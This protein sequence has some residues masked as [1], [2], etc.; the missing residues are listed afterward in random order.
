MASLDS[1]TPS[2]FIYRGQRNSTW[3]LRSTLHRT[4][5]FSGFSN[6][7][8][9]F[10][11]VLPKV[12]EAIETWTGRRWDLA[13]PHG[14]AKFAAFLQHNGFPTPLLDWTRSPYIAAYFAFESVWN[15]EPQSD[16]VSIYRFSASE[17]HR[18]YHQHNN[19][20]DLSP[21]VS[22]LAPRAV[23][24]HKLALQQGCFTWSTIPNAEEHIE[25]NEEF[26]HQFLKKYEIPAAERPCVMREL[27]SMGITAIH[28]MPSVESV[29][30][31]AWEDFLISFEPFMSEANSQKPSGNSI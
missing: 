6:L 8:I 28:M 31:K 14:L 16:L 19:V 10:D 26:P 23:G 15:L 2:A 24:N 7:R 13:H 12:H 4:G 18:R 3:T 30:R 29:C 25:A 11:T 22:I 17:W 9:Y 5:F 21:H 20:Q 27:S 1:T